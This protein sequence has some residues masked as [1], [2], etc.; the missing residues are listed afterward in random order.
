MSQLFKNT[1]GNTFVLTENTNEGII[2][3]NPEHMASKITQQYKTFLDTNQTK[4]NKQL[5][6]KKTKTAINT[7]KLKIIDEFLKQDFIFEKF[8]TLPLIILIFLGQYL[9]DYC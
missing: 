4:F 5:T 3:G 2:I 6:A 8:R 1:T 7:A 9:P